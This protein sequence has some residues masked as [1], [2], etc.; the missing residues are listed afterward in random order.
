MASTSELQSVLEDK[1]KDPRFWILIFFF[2]MGF[3][4][5]IASIESDWIILGDV[6][7]WFD[8]IVAGQLLGPAVGAILAVFLAVFV[9]QVL[10]ALVSGEARYIR[11]SGILSSL[12]IIGIILTLILG[13]EFLLGSGEPGQFFSIMTNNL[14]G[15]P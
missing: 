8:D 1:L 3:I 6:A 7:E 12:A 15:G 4:S 14:V 10:L 13:M 2:T 11:L 9:F 5:M